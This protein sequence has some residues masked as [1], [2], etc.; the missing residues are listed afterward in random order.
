MKIIKEGLF[1]YLFTFHLLPLSAAPKR[2][3]F[4]K[5]IMKGRLNEAKCDIFI[6]LDKNHVKML[7]P[8]SKE[9]LSQNLNPKVQCE[10]SKTT[11]S[12][13]NGKTTSNN[14]IK[15]KRNFKNRRNKY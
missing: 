2:N 5:R 9:S 15:Y 4:V 13:V 8:Y 7:T 6:R 14:S 1:K 11:A 3:I 12:V 10:I